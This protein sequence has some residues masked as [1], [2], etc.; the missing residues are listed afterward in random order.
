VR[1]VE[2]TVRFEAWWSGLN[3]DQQQAIDVRL[4][5][6]QEHGPDVGRP[7][8]ATIKTSGFFPEMHELIVDAEDSCLRVLFALDPRDVVVLLVG[9]DK[10]GEWNAW[11]DREVPNAD[12]LYA[13]HLE[14]LD[15]EA[16]KEV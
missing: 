12:R 5:L 7:V 1:K 11:Y 4:R 9:G 16:G 15:D 10:T 2:I 14:E 13:R 3:V 6:V 8:V